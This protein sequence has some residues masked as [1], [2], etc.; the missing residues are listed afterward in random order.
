MK[1]SK[2]ILL[3]LLLINFNANSQISPINEKE[4]V[5]FFNDL[6]SNSNL[7]IEK[8]S[9]RILKWHPEDINGIETKENPFFQ[10]SPLVQLD[11]VKKY[12][13]E[14]DI[15]F[16]KTQIP[17]LNQKDYWEEEKIHQITLIDSLEVNQILLKS[18][19][20]EKAFNIDVYF[21][22]KPLFSRDLNRV[23]IKQKYYCGFQCA[24]ECIYIYKKQKNGSWKEIYNWNC[25]SS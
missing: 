25:W 12:F 9:K 22:S 1:A 18:I 20:K 5:K 11:S 16:I 24:T 3:L 2:L 19:S 14:S 6:K 15:D 17:H 7:N 23:I 13:T 21:F 4:V 8:V 10:D